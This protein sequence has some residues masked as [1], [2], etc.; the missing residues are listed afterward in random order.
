MPNLCTTYAYLKWTWCLRDL[1]K[2]S[3]E[4]CSIPFQPE[5]PNW[6]N[7]SQVGLTVL[8]PK[9]E[10]KPKLIKKQVWFEAWKIDNLKSLVHYSTVLFACLNRYNL[11]DKYCD[12]KLQPCVCK[13]HLTVPWALVELATWK[14]LNHLQS[15]CQVEILAAPQF[16]M[17]HPNHHM[18]CHSCR[19][20]WQEMI[21]RWGK[22]DD[23]KLVTIYLRPQL[24]AICTSRVV[25]LWSP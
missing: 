13:N 8:V 19:W 11:F 9:L 12:P 16:I 21:Q 20:V 1:A 18:F 6:N 17:S 3:C 24:M 2:S 7:T 14:L 10:E 5:C 23:S 22:Y 15:P 4:F 25:K